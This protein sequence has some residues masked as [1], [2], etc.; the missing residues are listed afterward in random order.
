[1]TPNEY[2]RN[3]LVDV[4]LCKGVVSKAHKTL[5][6]EFTAPS[7]LAPPLVENPNRHINEINSLSEY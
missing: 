2:N 1:M 5:V 6:C 3:V 7:E 4:T